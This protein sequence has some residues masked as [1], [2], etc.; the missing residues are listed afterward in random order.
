MGATE[1]INQLLKSSG[2]KVVLFVMFVFIATMGYIQSWVFAGKDVGASKPPFYDL[3]ASFP[4][5]SLWMYLLLPLFPFSSL[6]SIFGLRNIFTGAFFFIGNIVYSYV[7]ASFMVFCY[8][9]Y[10]QNFTA[11]FWGFWI[12]V[13]I[14]FNITSYG[15]AFILRM[16]GE[17]VLFS[18]RAVQG[19][20]SGFVVGVFV[21]VFYGYILSCIFFLMR[22]RIKSRLLVEIF[23]R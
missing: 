21:T 15:G 11:K 22:G 2:L 9:K 16:L 14:I 18:E 20:V 13:A 10:K 4:F 8:E 23:E 19:F 6:L 12:G 5:W 3:L 17:P 1:K 7:L